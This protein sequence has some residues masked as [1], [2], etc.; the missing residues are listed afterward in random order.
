MLLLQA[1]WRFLNNE[2]VSFHQLNQP[3]EK[4]VF[5]QVAQLKHKY[6]LVAHDWSQLQYV[7][8]DNKINRIKRTHANDLSYELQS[9]LLVDVEQGLPIAPIAQ[10]LSDSTGRYSTFDD[11]FADPETHLNAL[12]QQ[13][14][15][16]EAMPIE[17]K[18][19]HIIDREGDSVARYREF[20]QKGYQWLIRGKESNTVEYLGQTLKLKD[21]TDQVA[22]H[23]IKCIEYKGQKVMLHVGEADIR[24]TRSAKPK[25]RNT[26]GKR[27]APQVGE[28]VDVRLVV[29][30][31]KDATGK[32]LSRW[33]LLSNV[34]KEISCTELSTWY[35]WRWSIESY[36]KLLK[37]AGHDVE[38]WLQTTPQAILRKLLVASMACVLTWRIQRCNDEQTT[39]VRAVLTR[40]SGRQQK[41]GKR[42]SAPSILAGLSILLNT[43]KLLESYSVD[44]LKEMAKIA[45]GYPHEDV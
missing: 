18:I 41:R 31:V 28:P 30:Q 20:E 37:Q 23:E 29:A 35:Y 15:H 14:D 40:L 32:V 3:I 33:S 43:L 39:R 7:K 1:V 21:V 10:T 25:Q 6:I 2:N 11:Q 13:I 16:I 4:L 36:F 5:D 44:E 27:V 26:E 34:A 22:T 42:E 45:L 17:Q 24:I 9:S 19:V 12:I 38:S 8:H